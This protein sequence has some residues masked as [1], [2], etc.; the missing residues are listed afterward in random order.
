[1]SAKP[2]TLDELEEQLKVCRELGATGAEPVFLDC[3]VVTGI[4]G[5]K[6]SARTRAH[7][8][9]LCEP[10]TMQIGKIINIWGIPVP[11]TNAE[12][13]GRCEE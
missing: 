10:L 5:L 13:S 8:A 3:S 12:V 6:I 11:E 1:M 7:H 2:I 4:E 9:G